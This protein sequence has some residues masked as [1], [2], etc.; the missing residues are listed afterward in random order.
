MTIILGAMEQTTP[1][2]FH[3]VMKQQDPC[4]RSPTARRSHPTNVLA[5]WRCRPSS[6]GCGDGG[7]SA[8]V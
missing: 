7:T 2:G 3:M 8:K 4:A 6:C 1:H 5:Q